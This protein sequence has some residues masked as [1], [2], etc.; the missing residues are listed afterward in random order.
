MCGP[1]VRTKRF[2]AL[3]LAADRGLELVVVTPIGVVQHHP[4]R[5]PD[6]LRR[7]G[8]PTDPPGVPADEFGL[9][10][11]ILVGPMSGKS[12]IVWVLERHGLEATDER[13]EKRVRGVATGLLDYLR[14]NVCPRLALEAMA[15]E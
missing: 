13:I 3:D 14:R 10:Q 1:V 15:R 4:I 11:T 6:L 9:K 7:L 8:L 12:N 2:R 5:V